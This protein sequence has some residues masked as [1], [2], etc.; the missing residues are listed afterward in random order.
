MRAKQLGK[1][2]NSREL[3]ALIHPL[4]YLDNCTNLTYLAFDYLTLAAVFA[5][6]ITFCEMRA[7]WG[8]SWVWNIP[9]VTLGVLLVGAVQHRFAGLGH[10]GAHWILL[11]N[12]FWNE[13]VSDWFFMFPLF[14]TTA[15]Y[16]LMHLGHHEYTNDWQRDPELLNMGQTRM[17]DRFPMT[18]AEFAKHFFSRIFWPP[19][20]LRYVWDNVYTTTF[21]YSVN[22]YQK[23]LPK[24]LPGRIGHFRITLLLGLAYLPVMVGILGWLSWHGT[25]P[26]LI[27]ASALL[28]TAASLVISALP[29]SW[30]FQSD[31]RP[32][33]S[34]K[35]TSILRLTW[36]TLLEGGLAWS[37][38][39]TGQEWGVYFWL[40]W[41]LP[42]LTSFPYYMLL[43][44][45]YQHANADDGKLT[46]SRVIF[47]NP[48]LRWA[49]FIYGQD[50]HLTHHLYPA[51]PHYKLR[52]LHRLLV[53][54]NEEYA[55]HVVECHGLI[56]PRAGKLSAL[57]CMEVPTCEPAPIEESH[58]LEMVEAVP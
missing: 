11:K 40:L 6:T 39:A 50:I 43:R 1:T 9:V 3:N 47:T 23:H 20:L 26:Q 18:R 8:L 32:V 13:L 12:R 2:L 27:G 36:F 30:F 14:S 35:F 58:A 37:R 38:Q 57:D 19:R 15:Q 25:L 44:D 51:V 33:Y 16:R 56:W 17:M 52:K 21:G 29:D 55:Q 53:E 10:E 34:S 22:P 46:N 5:S 42:L 28:L 41:V 4:R 49:M 7:G 24:S 45:L 31:F 48:V 54:N